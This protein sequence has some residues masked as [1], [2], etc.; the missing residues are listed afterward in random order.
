MNLVQPRSIKL[1]HQLEAVVLR[2]HYMRRLSSV[3]ELQESTVFL[4]RFERQFDDSYGKFIITHHEMI[5][6]G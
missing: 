6:G 2:T 5:V 1:Q 4:V 3:S